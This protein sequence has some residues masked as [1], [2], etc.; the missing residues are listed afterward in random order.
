VTLGKYFDGKR[1]VVLA[2]VYYSCPMLCTQIMN[3]VSS[4]IK[5]L[6]WTPGNEFDVVFISFDP[7]DKPETAAAKKIAV[8]C[9]DPAARTSAHTSSGENTSR[10]S[11]TRNRG[12]STL[13]AG[14]RA[15]PQTFIARRGMP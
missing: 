9:S 4:A 3:G 11:E 15:S 8:S 1:P 2:F 13:A 12:R 7:R 14:L 6:P 10:S 5:A